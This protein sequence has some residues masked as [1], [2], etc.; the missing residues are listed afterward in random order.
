MKEF[1]GTSIS[2]YKHCG[3]RIDEQD[4]QSRNITHLSIPSLKTITRIG[5]IGR[6]IPT[7]YH[8]K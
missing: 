5:C 8:R 2:G 4:I 3:Q 7:P 6:R 1:M